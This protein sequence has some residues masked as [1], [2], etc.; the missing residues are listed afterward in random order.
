M[1]LAEFATGVLCNVAGITY[2]CC[3]LQYV[4]PAITQRAQNRTRQD[5]AYI[6][7]SEPP[8]RSVRGFPS[9]SILLLVRAR[10]GNYWG[11]FA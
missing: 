2:V 10:H 5:Y 6:P 11:I 8:L 3:L 1:H 9:T 4:I 7:P